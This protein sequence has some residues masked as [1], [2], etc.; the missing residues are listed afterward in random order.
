MVEYQP[1]PGR[2][3]RDPRRLQVK[4]DTTTD[5]TV[6]GGGVNR[7]V[8][9]KWHTIQ[10]GYDDIDVLRI[11]GEPVHADDAGGVCERGIG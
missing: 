8:D 11:L 2:I 5:L 1:P 7:S 4:P 10:G 6:V 9:I 3:D